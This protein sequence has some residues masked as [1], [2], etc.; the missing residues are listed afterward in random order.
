MAADDDSFAS[1]SLRL[2]DRIDRAFDRASPSSKSRATSIT[3]RT[4]AG[5]FIPNDAPGGFILEDA[6]QEAGG[7][8]FDDAAATGG[9]LP[10]SRERSPSNDVPPSGDDTIPFSCIPHALQIL[11]LPPDDEEV[12]AV[13]RNAASGWT[14]GARPRPGSDD[15]E[16]AEERVS[17]KDWRS[18]C[19]VLM[20][21]DDDDALMNEDVEMGDTLGELEESDL[22]G[23]SSDE[24]VEPSPSKAAKR[25]RTTAASTAKATSSKTRRR[26][27][28][29]IS[30]EGDNFDASRPLTPRQKR[31]CLGVFTLFFPGVSE[32]FIKRKRIGIKE[33]TGASDLLKEKIKVEEM[34]D[35][36]EAFSSSPDKT[37]GLADFEKM[38]V[39]THLV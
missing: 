21:D 14:D 22:E 5:G 10:P 28:K 7:F 30:D 26:K 4:G 17:R 35:M 3:S 32:E 34:I 36:L 6:E 29:A 1:L 37:M 24:Y 8:L 18:V 11:D 25:K 33:L 27:D 19:A 12:L 9:F 16:A 2:R 13:L 39:T 15:D 23:G 20:N 31:E 38:M